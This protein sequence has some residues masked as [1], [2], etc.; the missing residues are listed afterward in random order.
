MSAWTPGGDPTAWQYQ[1]EPSQRPQEAFTPISQPS[2]I[3]PLFEPWNPQAGYEQPL[4]STPGYDQSV[5]GEQGAYQYNQPQSQSQS[6]ASSSSQSHHPQDPSYSSSPYP[7]TQHNSYVPI[8]APPN[9]PPPPSQPYLEDSNQNSSF[10]Y[11]PN[12]S[13]TDHTVPHPQSG[14]HLSAAAQRFQNAAPSPSYDSPAPLPPSQLPQQQRTY[15]PS[16]RPAPAPAT[17]QQYHRKVD[18][19][20]MLEHRLSQLEG[21]LSRG[22]MSDTGP[23]SVQTILPN[24]RSHLEIQLREFKNRQVNLLGECEAFTRHFGPASTWTNSHAPPNGPGQ[25]HRLAGPTQR[26]RTTSAGLQ[27]EQPDIAAQAPHRQSPYDG[28]AYNG[29]GAR[30]DSPAQSQLYDDSRVSHETIHPPPG[31]HGRQIPRQTSDHTS[32][33]S[34]PV[35]GHPAPD[36]HQPV[37]YPNHL[38]HQRYTS[39]PHS[40]PPP[41][42]SYTHLSNGSQQT[43]SFSFPAQQQFQNFPPSSSSSSNH[44]Y[45]AYVQPSA[46][47]YQPSSAP[48]SLRYSDQVSQAQPVQPFPPPIQQHP[49]SRPPPAS[50]LVAPPPPTPP[51]QLPA[52]LRA[53]MDVL[54]RDQAAKNERSRNSTNSNSSLANQNPLQLLVKKAENGEMPVMTMSGLKKQSEVEREKKEQEEREK[55]KTANSGNGNEKTPTAILADLCRQGGG[56]TLAEMVMT[57]DKDVFQTQLEQLCVKRNI[58]VMEEERRGNFVVETKPVDL[59]QL[60]QTVVSRG[61]GYGKIDAGNAWTHVATLLSVPTRSTAAQARVKEI[62]HR[63]LRPYEDIWATQMIKL[64]EKQRA[65][66]EARRVL[67]ATPASNPTSASPH[68]SAIY[69]PTLAP[70]RSDPSPHSTMTP[71]LAPTNPTARRSPPQQPPRP[72]HGS[73]SMFANPISYSSLSDAGSYPGA[74]PNPYQ[75]SQNPPTSASSQSTIPAEKTVT[76]MELLEQARALYKNP[77]ATANK[78]GGGGGASTSSVLPQQPPTTSPPQETSS[79]PQESVNSSVP[80]PAPVVEPPAK[81]SPSPSSRPKSTSNSRS[82][83]QSAVAAAGQSA[84]FSTSM[85]QLGI[86]TPS[87]ASN[88]SPKTRPNSRKRKTAESD[89]VDDN[90]QRRP[91]KAR[92]C[93]MSNLE[94]PVVGQ[95]TNEPHFNPFEITH[96]LPFT[97][98]A[99]SIVPSPTSILPSQ[100]LYPDPSNSAKSTLSNPS[101]QP[102]NSSSTSG[103][104]ISPH[105][106][107]DGLGL[108]SS[109]GTFGGGKR[110]LKGATGTTPFESVTKMPSNFGTNSPLSAALDPSSLDSIS[111]SVSLDHL[112]TSRPGT[113][114]S[115]Q[116]P[117]IANGLSAFDTFSGGLDGYSYPANE[118]EGGL[119]GLDT[120]YLSNSMSS[121]GAGL[122]NWSPGGL[123]GFDFNSTFS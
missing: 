100:P 16:P 10:R 106:M 110:T 31:P 95:Q 76:A 56:P 85:A 18:E 73:S 87:M 96:F 20:A 101:L 103:E 29:E 79:T 112:A 89:T 91:S 9:H 64:K 8:L 63:I 105:S 35:G 60:F 123:D 119:E 81:P 42:S 122:P 48:Q 90:S 109:P 39:S 72:S 118:F 5:Y 67:G 4:A 84:P 77:N 45:P 58:N 7:T 19:L 37:Q 41:S 27:V 55:A 99:P 57:I 40:A 98:A 15:V 51:Q 53:Q 80:A 88:G 38:S 62:Y 17:I 54:A 92:D 116:E 34:T 49:S 75:V 117:V 115:M 86:G 104:T 74:A 36:P 28:Q 44:A 83:V 68:Q 114:W 94:A 2:S 71:Q 82:S 47:L 13:A 78:Q 23:G 1:Q 97:T 61:G 59:M 70:P 26:S 111:L 21:I 113:S 30:F 50:T 52:G 93:S 121:N 24:Q 32:R 22:T 6:F 107:K 46:Q 69:Q 11:A 14:V 102:D 66:D 43:G 120:R 3:N 25:A 65:M 108:E 33:G 12:P